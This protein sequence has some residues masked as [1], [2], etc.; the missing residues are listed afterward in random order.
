MAISEGIAPVFF[1]MS[2]KLKNFSALQFEKLWP[3]L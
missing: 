2:L 3:Q 1:F